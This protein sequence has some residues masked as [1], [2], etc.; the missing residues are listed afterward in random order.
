MKR[1]KRWFSE[2][3]EAPEMNDID[4]VGIGE[5]FNDSAIRTRWIIGILD[6][7]KRINLEVDRRL[8]NGPDYG[9]TDL[10]ARRKAFQDV[11]ESVLAAKRAVAQ[12][13]RP[14]PR[15]QVSSVNLDR[16]TV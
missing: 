14:N 16:V 15:S 6:E 10:C 9:L 5:A 8:L 13:V 1:V 4:L 2:M 7:I 11:L 3:F 12:E